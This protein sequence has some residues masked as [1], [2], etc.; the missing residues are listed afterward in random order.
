MSWQ[1]CHETLIATTAN[2]DVPQ[3]KS[4]ESAR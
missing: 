1:L 3:I 2:V 4:S